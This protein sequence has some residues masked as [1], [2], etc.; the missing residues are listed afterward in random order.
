M[1]ITLDGNEIK[2]VNGFV[3]S[4]GIIS[5]DSQLDVEVRCL[6]QRATN[7]WRKGEGVCV[8]CVTPAYLNDMDIVTLTEQQHHK[9][10][11]CENS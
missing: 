1:N 5:V 10:R 6:I 9:L 4:G 7:A 3:I 11:A 2:Q 8:S